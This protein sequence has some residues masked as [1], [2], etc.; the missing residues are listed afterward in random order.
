MI[1]IPLFFLNFK[2][3]FPVFQ[4]EDLGE[5]VLSSQGISGTSGFAGFCLSSEPF[6]AGC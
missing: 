6:G 3:L 2:F 5:V 1:Y 4:A